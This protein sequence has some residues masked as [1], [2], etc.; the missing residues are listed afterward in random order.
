MYLKYVTQIIAQASTKHTH[1]ITWA[2]IK[3]EHY[4]ASKRQKFLVF[5]MKIYFFIYDYLFIY[6]NRL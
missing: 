1:Y 5:S 6:A 3:T 4:F 2:G